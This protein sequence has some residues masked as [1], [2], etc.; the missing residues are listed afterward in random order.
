MKSNYLI[1]ISFAVFILLIVSSSSKVYTEEEY[2]VLQEKATFNLL[3]Y[4]TYYEMFKDKKIGLGKTVEELYHEN[5]LAHEEYLQNKSKDFLPNIDFETESLASYSLPLQYDPK[6]YYPQ[7][8]NQ[9]IK[10][11][12]TC[13]SCY[14]FSATFALAKRYCIKNSSF[15]RNLDLSPQDMISCE[16]SNNKCKGGV[17]IYNYSFL[18]HSGVS[19]EV[20]TPYRSYIDEFNVE[21]YP[22]C[23]SICTSYKYSYIKYKIKSGTVTTID[24]YYRTNEEAIKFDIYFNGPVST[25]M[26]AFDDLA[27]YEGGIYITTE[28]DE[29]KAEGHAVTIV[30][31]G[32]DYRYGEYWIVANS[33]GPTWGD[34]GYFYIPFGHSKIARYT[35]S[36]KPNLL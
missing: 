23:R 26:M 16:T 14:S 4:E 25:S 31:W 27:T 19:E 20:C 8:F 33:W 10:D 6:A 17:L 11:Q 3:P 32:R 28:T 9:P 35:V 12:G 13:G 7:C 22:G 34:K 2:K 36:G 5:K 21:H 18:E 24:N 29:T 1:L 15:Y 30:G